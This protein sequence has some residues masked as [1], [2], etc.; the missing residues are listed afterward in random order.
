[1]YYI[2]RLLQ[3]KQ[4]KNNIF[5]MEIFPKNSHKIF[6]INVPLISVLKTRALYYLILKVVVGKRKF[7]VRKV[8]RNLTI[9]RSGRGAVT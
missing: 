5:L 3:A 8:K 6:L 9:V 7:N 2:Y 1:M 4:F